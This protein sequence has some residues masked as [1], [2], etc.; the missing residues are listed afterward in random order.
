MSTEAPAQEVI[1]DEFGNTVHQDAEPKPAATGEE[2][3]EGSGEEGGEEKPFHAWD[4][5]KPEPK[6]PAHVPYDRFKQVN[7]ERTQF[8]E[9][10]RALAKQLQELEAKLAKLDQVVDPEEIKIEDYDTPQAYLA[11][12]DKAVAAKIKAEVA[13]DLTRKEQERVQ[14]QQIQAIAQQF[15][16]NLQKHAAEDPNVMKA[17]DFFD[18]YAENVPPEVGKELLSDPNVGHVMVRIATNQ[19]LLTKFFQSTPDQAI[20]LINRIS[21]R[22]EAERELKP[23]ASPAEDGAGVTPRRAAPVAPTALQLPPDPRAKSQA[24]MP[25]QVKATPT[26]GRLDLYRDAE[27]MTMQQ[28]REARRAKKV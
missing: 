26:P 23:A 27:N 21:A 9:D 16:A 10:N 11:A 20:R 14:E 5:P 1:E 6:L 3:G 28:W 4:L 13:A 19:E 8:F 22:I 12:R 7:E 17:K 2:G 15:T 25:V 18:A 24:A